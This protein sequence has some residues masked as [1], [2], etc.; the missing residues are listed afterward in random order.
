[1]MMVIRMPLLTTGTFDFLEAEILNS[2]GFID[3][4]NT[5]CLLLALV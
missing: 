3:F 4:A 1:M 2:R 5:P